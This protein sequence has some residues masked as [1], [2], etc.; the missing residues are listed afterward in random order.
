MVATE[1]LYPGGNML[2]GVV[3]AA[4]FKD[5]GFLV[6]WHLV[7]LPDAGKSYPFG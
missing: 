6:L 7:I 4:H 3:E 2:V 1:L 5:P